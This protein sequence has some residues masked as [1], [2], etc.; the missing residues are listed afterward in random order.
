MD[1]DN[2]VLFKLIKLDGFISDNPIKIVF[3][4]GANYSIIFSDVINRLGLN[5]FINNDYINEFSGIGKTESK[6]RIN[7]IIQIN[8][9]YYDILLNVCDKQIDDIDIILG[10]DFLYYNNV[11]INFKTDTI[12]INDDKEF[13]FSV[14]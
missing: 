12:K 8:N 1:F 2:Q 6:G 11:I 13:L 4:T 7:H 5:S 3:D 10:I 9:R 14:S